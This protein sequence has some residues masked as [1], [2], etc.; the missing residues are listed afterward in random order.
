M[1]AT[2]IRRP[3]PRQSVR[4]AVDPVLKAYRRYGA[5]EDEQEPVNERCRAL[6]DGLVERLGEPPRGMTA[7]DCWRLDPASAELK[8]SNKESDMLTGK[9]FV[10]TKKLN[11]TRATTL[12]GVMAKL[13]V[14]LDVWPCNEDGNGIEMDTAIA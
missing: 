12:P 3:T 1:S 10:A 2:T 9:I 5:L 14:A 4:T 7:A 11:D 6:R 8:R 13:Q